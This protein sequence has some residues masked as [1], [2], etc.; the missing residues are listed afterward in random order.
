MDILL[1]A[2]AILALVGLNAFFVAAEFALVGARATRLQTLAE[3][4][5]RKA[6]VALSALAHLDDCISSTQL[7][8]T[9]ASLGLGWIGETTL[10]ALLVH[11]FA[12]LPA[13]L[14]PLAGHTV[15]ATLAF[16]GITVLHIVL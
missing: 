11:I 8:I 4:G 9:L 2:W 15:A 7:G 10:A 5:D 3:G 12:G 6:S 14:A 1:K 13:P 16:A